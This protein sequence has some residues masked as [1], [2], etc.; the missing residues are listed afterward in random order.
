MAHRKNKVPDYSADSEWPPDWITTY[1]DLTTL[2]MTFFIILSTM[3]A[4]NIDITWVA[5]KEYIEIDQ[6]RREDTIDVDLTLEERELLKKIR[7][8]KRQQMHELAKINEIQ[9]MAKEIQQYIVDANLTSFVRV[10]ASK[11]KLKIVPVAPFLFRPGGATLTPSGKEFVK[12]ISKLF[13]LSPT[14]QIRV[15][16]HTDNVPIHTRRYPSNWE[17]S[18]A[19]S[20][21]VMRYLIDECGINPSVLSSIGYGPHKPVMSN[22]TE[23][24]RS[25]NRRVEIEIIQRPGMDIQSLL[26]EDNTGEAAG[27]D[28]GVADKEPGS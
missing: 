11:W 7:E 9:R 22:E 21:S 20:S 4:L 25:K 27:A 28:A 10:E 5:G 23:E 1:A 14:A 6:E 8:L 15:S 24:G 17:L 2:L 26:P 12:L 13:M 19:R 16:G 18:C 3:L